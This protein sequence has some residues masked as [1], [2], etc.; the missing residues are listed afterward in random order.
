VYKYVAVV[1]YAGA[2]DGGPPGPVLT[3]GTF[4]CFAD[5][6]FSNLPILDGSLQAFEISVFAY[7]RDS[8]PQALGCGPNAVPCP[9]DD[10]AAVAPYE[11]QANWTTTCIAT[12]Q[13]G[14]TAPAACGALEPSTAGSSAD[15]SAGDGPPA[16][17][18]NAE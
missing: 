15:G 6:L 9:G 18:S 1:A 8:F 11:V 2:E 16:D 7:N 12:E 13:G 17:G 3:S 14:A 5:G 10:A 4:D